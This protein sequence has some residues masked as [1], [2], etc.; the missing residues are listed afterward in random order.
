MKKEHQTGKKEDRRIQ[1]TRKK[2]K[3]ALLGLLSEHEFSSL[4]VR[5]ICLTAGITTITFY[6]YYTDKYALA[7]EVFHDM[8]IAAEQDFLKRQEKN[9]SEKDPV[10]GCCNILDCLLMLFGEED[11]PL[12]GVSPKTGSYLYLALSDTIM[13]EISGFLQANEL[14]ASY[15]LDMVTAFLCN[16]IWGFISQG[17]KEGRDPQEIR[18]EAHSLICA[19]M[20]SN[21][22]ES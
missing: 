12:P 2:L 15:S 8:A 17:Q 7:D 14:K 19:L 20:Q 22:F 3:D 9:N 5:Q 16:G 11:S 21:I 18:S 4:S 1:N 10:K 13:K 6:T